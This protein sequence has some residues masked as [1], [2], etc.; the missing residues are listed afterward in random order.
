MPSLTPLVPVAS[1][2]EF[3]PRASGVVAAGS[4]IFESLLAAGDANP[5]FQIKGDGDIEW[6]AG[7]ASAL[8]TNLYRFTANALATD[9][10]L[11]SVRSAT[12]DAAFSARIS[13]DGNGRFIV[14]ASGNLEWGDGTAAPDTTLY[15]A[16]ADVLRTSDALSVG[17]NIYPDASIIWSSD[18]NLY[19]SAADVLASDDAFRA[20]GDLRAN[21]GSANSVWVGHTGSALAAQITFGSAFDTNLYRVSANKLKTDDDFV[22][23]RLEVGSATPGDGFELL[24]LTTSRS[25]V[26]ETDGADGGTQALALRST[27]GSKGFRIQDSDGTTNFEFGTGTGAGSGSIGFFGTA[28]TTKKTVTGSRGG[29]AALASLLTQLAAYGL[30]TDSTSA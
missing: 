4:D 15:R 23:L 24:R 8:D 30:I 1:D 29:N 14:R 3:V 19:R 7:G 26:F 12:G 18:T 22:A 11:L 9:D 5:A 27:T 10:H 25:W 6:G 13:S 21:S 17:G 16:S 28:A 2:T 20:V